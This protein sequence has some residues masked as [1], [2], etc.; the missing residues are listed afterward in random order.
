MRKD[1]SVV[2]PDRQDVFLNRPIL[3]LLSAAVSQDG[4][5][6]AHTN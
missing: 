2:K 6:Q 5:M 4:R 1:S 3:E